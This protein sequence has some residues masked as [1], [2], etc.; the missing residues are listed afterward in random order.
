[1]NTLWPTHVKKPNSES[2]S[3]PK[4]ERS[5]IRQRSDNNKNQ[6]SK[7]SFESITKSKKKKRK[8]NNLRYSY[9]QLIEFLSIFSC[10][11]KII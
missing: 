7:K 8:K 11:I 6:L 2:I 1:M 9:K 5:N 10:D 4:T 3:E